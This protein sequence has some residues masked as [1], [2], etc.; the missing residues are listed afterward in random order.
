MFSDTRNM[1]RVRLSPDL[2][3]KRNMPSSLVCLI[4]SLPPKLKV[5]RRSPYGSCQQSFVRT[6]GSF[7]LLR[8]SCLHSCVGLGILAATVVPLVH[9]RCSMPSLRRQARKASRRRPRLSFLCPRHAAYSWCTLPTWAGIFPPPSPSLPSS[10]PS[11][12]RP[13]LPPF[14]PSPLYSSL[15]PLPP[16]LSPPPLPLS[17]PPSFRPL[18]ALS[19]LPHPSPHSPPFRMHAQHTPSCYS[20]SSPKKADGSAYYRRGQLLPV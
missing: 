8:L 19:L 18:S 17:L 3:C 12:L 14:L 16:S 2:L 5:H 15:C 1:L 10:L 9:G 20:S 6:E 7:F 4:F 11:S 13:S